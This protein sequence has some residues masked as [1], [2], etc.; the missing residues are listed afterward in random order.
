MESCGRIGKTRHGD[1]LAVTVNPPM[2]DYPRHYSLVDRLLMRLPRPLPAPAAN[3]P[4]PAAGVDDAA[5]DARQK[6]HSAGLM[7]VNHAG[8]VS[9][10][11]LYQG[12]ALVARDPRVRAQLLHAA[13]E[14]QAHLRWCAARL[15]EL[16]D[17]PSQLSPLWYAGSFAIGALAGLGGDAASLGFVE[18]T[19]NQVVKHLDEHLGALPSGDARS[20]AVLGAMQEDEK[21]HGATAAAAGAR[22]LPRP[23]RA[24][25]QRVA[26]VMKF[27]AYRV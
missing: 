21:R 16:D 24:L 5:L 26:S 10:Q 25:M 20:R 13:E 14:E 7:R 8:E 6:R 1:K 3:A 12:Q 23:V 9:A 15:A 4:Y 18:E 2:P 22:P 17:R 11:A 19:E 27:G